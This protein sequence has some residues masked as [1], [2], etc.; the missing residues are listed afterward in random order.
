MVFEEFAEVLHVNANVNVIV[1][2]HGN[3][4]AVALTDAEA[5]VKYYLVLKAVVSNRLLQKLNN[6]LRALKVTG[7]AYANL[8]YNHFLY[9]RKHR[10]LKEAVNAVGSNRINLVLNAYANAHLALA[11]AEGTGKLN[12]VAERLFRNKS[13]KSL[14]NLARALDMA[15]AADAYCDFHVF[16]LFYQ[17]TSVFQKLLNSFSF[18]V[19]AIE[20]EAVTIGI[21]LPTYFV[22]VPLLLQ[23]SVT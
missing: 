21:H 20:S 7:R 3:A 22:S 4:N 6:I 13:L 23:Y 1:Y 10:F 11:H 9:P 5:T 8:Y 15:G 19:P 14:N 18:S 16:Y 12:L 17:F 2:L